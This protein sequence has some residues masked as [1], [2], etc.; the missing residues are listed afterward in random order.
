MPTEKLPE[1]VR[2]TIQHANE[3]AAMESAATQQMAN[4]WLMVRNALDDKINEVAREIASLT[5]AGKEVT[6]AWLNEQAYYR[7]LLE[8]ADNQIAKYAGW[9]TKYTE[10]QVLDSIAMG[11]DQATGTLQATRTSGMT[12]FK[13]LPTPQIESIQAITMRDAPLGQLFQNIYPTGVLNNPITDALMS[14]LS[15]G[16]PMRGIAELMSHAV[17]MPFERSLLIARTEVN[18]A[19]RSSSLQ[20]YQ[21]FDVPYYRRIASRGHACFSCTLLD[22]TLYS[23]HQALDDHPNGACQMVPVLD[24]DDPS[25]DWEHG[26]KRFEGMTEAQQRNIMGN[27][28]YDAWKRGDFQ[29]QDAV[30]IRQN[31]IWGGSPGMRPLKDLSPDYKSFRPTTPHKKAQI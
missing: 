1:V 18:R 25:T 7:A 19:H 16:M 4:R 21:E 13:G 22:G 27:N 20:T 14:G 30:V 29:L 9:A 31:P 23:S 6:Q 10:Q 26:D 11:I 8:Q 5:E 15:Q 24:P 3:L 28:Y 2:L 12:Y 17:N